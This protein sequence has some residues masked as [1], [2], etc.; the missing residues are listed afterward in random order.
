MYYGDNPHDAFITPTDA[1]KHELVQK[2][3]KS[4]Q[5]IKKCYNEC[6]P[7]RY[8]CKKLEQAIIYIN[9][10]PELKRESH[11]ALFKKRLIPG[12]LIHLKNDLSP[13][14]VISHSFS[15]GAVTSF[16]HSGPAL[17]VR[18]E[19]SVFRDQS[20]AADFKPRRHYLPYGKWVCGDGSEVLYNR[21]YYPLWIRD[22]QGNVTEIDADTWVNYVEDIYLF[23]GSNRPWENSEQELRRSEAWRELQA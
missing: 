2:C 23:E 11:K 22:R 12:T 4:I 15:G 19:V 5:I 14:V 16:G 7:V 3:R 21:D 20:K 13:M 18:Y 6:E 17:V 1:F 10:W 9:S 8:I